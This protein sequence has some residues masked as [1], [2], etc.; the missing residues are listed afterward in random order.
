MD[1]SVDT[2]KFFENAGQ[3]RSMIYFKI[4]VYKF[5]KKN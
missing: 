4:K 3:T 2:E 1:I 5:L